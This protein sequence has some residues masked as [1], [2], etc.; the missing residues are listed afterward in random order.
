MGPEIVGEKMEPEKFYDAVNVI[1]SLH[2]ENGGFSGW[3]PATAGLWIEWLNPVEFLEDGMVE[4]EHVECTSSAMQALILFKEFYPEHRTREIEKCIAK[5]VKFL[6]ETQKPN[7]SLYGSWGVCFIYGTWFALAGLVAAGKTYNNCVAIRK[8]VGFL[9][10]TQ[11]DDGGW[12][13][14]YLSYT[15]KVYTPLPGNRSNL[16]QTAMA[17]MGLIHGGQAKRDPDPLHRAAKLLINSQLPDDDFPQQEMAGAFL[18]NGILHY[19]YRK[20]Y[21]TW[22]LAEYS[23]HVAFPPKNI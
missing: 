3:E 16:V 23:K 22:A 19:A 4:R 13:E 20:S 11:T 12:G 5:A 18:G 2:S 14:S 9:L 17:F 21:P 6:K 1:L 10:K 15:K 7:G 8:G